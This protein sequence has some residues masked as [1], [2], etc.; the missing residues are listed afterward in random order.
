V[1]DPEDRWNKRFA[2]SHLYT[3]LDYPGFQ[4]FL[5]IKE[6]TSYRKNPVP[7]SR[8]KNLGEICR[9]LYGS[10]SNDQKPLV[11]TQNPDLRR[12]AEALQNERGID[13]LRSGL[14][15]EVAVEAAKGDES[16]FREALLQAKLHMGKA[17]GT[18]VTGDDGKSDTYELAEDIYRLAGKLLDAMEEN[19]SAT[20]K[21]GRG[22]R[23]K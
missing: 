12:L 19:R 5:G 16:I 22:T 1:F 2:F 10:Q 9:W 15:L 23:R 7:K 14:P 11:R 18:C 17:Y 8:V 21:R 13:A 3:G 20:P 6:E 4:Q